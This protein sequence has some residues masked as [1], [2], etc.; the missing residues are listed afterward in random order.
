MGDP[1][2][3]QR[4]VTWISAIVGWVCARS[5][6]RSTLE[7]VFYQLEPRFDHS[8]KFL[9]PTGDV[10]FVG[11]NAG[12]NTSSVNSANILATTTVPNAKAEMEDLYRYA[13]YLAKNLPFVNM[14]NSPFQHTV[15]KSNLKGPLPQGIFYELTPQDYVLST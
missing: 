9:L 7:A 13:N 12:D 5:G 8:V 6:F 10:L 11:G 4:E 15:Y 14:P 3:Q 1:H 2:A